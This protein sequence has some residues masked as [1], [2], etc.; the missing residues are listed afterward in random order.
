MRGAI[1]GI[2]ICVS[3]QFRASDTPIPWRGF[4]HQNTNARRATTPCIPKCENARFATAACAKMY[5]SIDHIAR[6][7]S[8]N[9]KSKVLLQFWAIDTR[10][11]LPESKQNLRFATVLGDQHQVFDET[12]AWEQTK[13]AFC[14]R[15]G[16]SAPRF[17]RE[18]CLR[19]NKICVSLQFWAIDST[20][21]ARRLTASKWNLRFATVLGDRR[22]VFSERVDFR[23]TLPIPPGGRKK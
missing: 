10:R 1:P 22:R 21:L 2:K 3:L 20:F 11:R 19:A 14:Y 23:L 8:R 12:V 13:F 16:R 17:W 9:E 6:S 5:A 7:A 4:I 15:F 18:G